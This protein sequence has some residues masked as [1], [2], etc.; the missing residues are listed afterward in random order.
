[1]LGAIGKPLTAAALERLLVAYRPPPPGRVS[2][3]DGTPA[4]V[5]AEL[6]D[7]RLAADFEPIVDLTLGSITAALVRARWPGKI[8]GDPLAAVDA[9][10]LGQRLAE[11]LLAR[12]R[13]ELRHL[14][15]DAW[16]PLPP[17]V[18]ADVLVADALAAILR[19][20]VVLVV[21]AAAVAR[22]D[23]PA[24]L[25]LL[26]RLRVKGYGLCV[27]GFEA[28]RESLERLPLT[29]VE[30]PSRLVATAATGDGAHAARLAEA[31]AAAGALGVPVVGRCETAAEFELLL[32]LGCSF[33]RG[34][35]L[36]PPTPSAELADRIRTWAPPAASD[37]VR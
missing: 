15:L 32:Q 37:G 16:V 19:D 8:T 14:D 11:H 9:A 18:L 20:R 4:A 27:D 17:S 35:F 29:H 12:A 7:G 25:D 33:A 2:S 34:P 26:A 28:G 22:R 24:R 13:E 3:A 23:D 36:A 1:V 5:A 6:E 30:L 21:D 31:L 10:G